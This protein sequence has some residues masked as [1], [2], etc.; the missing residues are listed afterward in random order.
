M[1]PRIWHR[2]YDSGVPPRYRVRGDSAATGS[3]T[4]RTCP[5]RCARRHLSQLPTHLPPAQGRGRPVR[6]R[7]GGAWGRQRHEGGD[8]ASQS[9]P[10]R[11]RLLRYALTR[12]AGGDD[13]PLVCGTGESHT[14]G[15]MLDARSPSSP[16]SSSKVASGAFVMSCRSSATSSHRS[17]S[18]C[19]SLSTSSRL[20]SSGR[21]VPLPSRRWNPTKAFGS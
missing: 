17:R 13:Q 10:S 11:D 9:A 18:T 5:W 20:S 19:A 2:F 7:A 14:S 16:T 21:L 8:P 3:R 6:H 4:E 15:T 12:S 1:E